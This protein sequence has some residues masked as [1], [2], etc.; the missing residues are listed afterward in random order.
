MIFT[1]LY[2]TASVCVIGLTVVFILAVL[3]KET[4][5]NNAKKQKKVSHYENKLPENV[6][7]G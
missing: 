5:K 1:V 2:T 3:N 4:K 6:R 7:R